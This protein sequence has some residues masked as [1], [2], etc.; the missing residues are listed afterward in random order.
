MASKAKASSSRS[1]AAVGKQ[2]SKVGKEL[3]RLVVRDLQAIL[4]PELHNQMERARL[5]LKIPKGSP[6]DHAKVIRS[7]G[8]KE[9]RAIQKQ[10]L[11]RR[12]EQGRGAHEPDVVTRTAWWLELARRKEPDAVQM[13]LAQ[14]QRD[15]G[16]AK[17]VG[18]AQTWR[19]VAAI[20][21]RTGSPVIVVALE[22]ADLVEAAGDGMFDALPWVWELPVVISYKAFLKLLEDEHARTK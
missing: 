20:H 17:V 11:I 9:L 12:G 5:K 10:S 15:L 6:A 14:G 1:R 22:L 8:T 18:K 16:E 7:E 3:E 13:K 4:E 19:R 21:R 2:N